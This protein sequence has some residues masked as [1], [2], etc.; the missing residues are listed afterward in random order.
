MSICARLFET[1]SALTLSNLTLEGGCVESD[2]E[3]RG[4]GALYAYGLTPPSVA[5]NN[6]HVKNNKAKGSANG[7]AVF[8]AYRADNR[9]EAVFDKV[10]FESN[11]AANGGAIYVDA[12]GDT[13]RNTIAITNSTFTN[14]QANSNSKGNVITLVSGN[15]VRI[16]IVNS[17][18]FQNQNLNNAAI[19]LSNHKGSTYVLNSTLIS[20]DTAFVFA[21]KPARLSLHNTVISDEIEGSISGSNNLEVSYNLLEDSLKCPESGSGS[22]LCVRASDK[23]NNEFLAAP[24]IEELHN[25]ELTMME[26]GA[27]DNE[28]CLKQNR[29]FVPYLTV[30]ETHDDAAEPLKLCKLISEEEDGTKVEEPVNC[31]LERG[32]PAPLQTGVNAPA[33]CRTTDMRG[34]SR[35]AGG[36]CDRGAYETQIN[37]AM[38]DVGNNTSRRSRTALL[39]VLRNDIPGDDMWIRTGTIVPRKLDNLNSEDENNDDTLALKKHFGDKNEK[40]SKF[41]ELGKTKGELIVVKAEVPGADL[42]LGDD[43]VPQ[44]YDDITITNADGREDPQS[45]DRAFNPKYQCLEDGDKDEECLIFYEAPKNYLC[46]DLPF[47]DYFAYSVEAWKYDST[48]PL[49]KDELPEFEESEAAELFTGYVQVTIANIAPIVPYGGLTYRIN[50]GDKVVVKLKDKGVKA[51]EGGVSDEIPIKLEK[52]T[53]DKEP[54]FALRSGRTH[55]VLGTGLFLNSEEMTVTYV[56]SDVSK[57]FADTF[58]VKVTDS[59]GASSIVPIRIEF[60]GAEQAGGNTPWAMTFL[61][62]VAGAARRKLLLAKAA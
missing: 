6:V 31:I 61:L 28:D 25:G 34:K 12:I 35:E 59:C 18:F 9:A 55:E 39:N 37:T 58:S 32:N 36:Q 2:S 8:L 46:S 26:G 13:S 49:D 52:L 4:G 41:L 54:K 15:N 30:N 24:S 1:E 60:H 38:P 44:Y 57:T 27:E 50:P 62:V 45:T 21:A 14:N 23:G 40:L 29:W 10:F 42:S 3:N 7:G 51:I 33:N 56:H 47:E 11:T 43:P 5:M 22:K 19:D 48:K 53:L 17:L 16:N 20:N